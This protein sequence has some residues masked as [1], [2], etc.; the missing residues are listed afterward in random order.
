MKTWLSFAG[1]VIYLYIKAATGLII[2]PKKTGFATTVRSLALKKVSWST[3]CCVQRRVE[4]W[5]LQISWLQTTTIWDAKC[6][7]LKLAWE[8]EVLFII[9]TL[10]QDSPSIPT[11]SLI[12]LQGQSN[13]LVLHP[14][15]WKMDRLSWTLHRIRNDSFWARTK[16]GIPAL[17]LLLKKRWNSGPKYGRW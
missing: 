13:Q 4:R 12:F 10:L 9:I 5:N 7:I 16:R 1:Y 15:I 2:F 3:V 11:R 6:N 17:L 14:F 8:K